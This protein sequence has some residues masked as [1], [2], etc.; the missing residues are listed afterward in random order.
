MAIRFQSAIDNSIAAVQNSMDIK[1][2]NAQEE[3][4]RLLDKIM[5]HKDDMIDVIDTWR[6]IKEK[7]LN[8]YFNKNLVY[9]S[10]NVRMIGVCIPID[11]STCKE[12]KAFIGMRFNNWKDEGGGPYDWYVLFDGEDVKIYINNIDEMATVKDMISKAVYDKQD[13]Y[14][15]MPIFDKWYRHTCHIYTKPMKALAYFADHIEDFCTE[16]F[17][18]AKNITLK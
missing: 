13:D 2:K 17:N 6:Y 8:K 3:M 5:K 4:Q 7:G 11:I 15:V 18:E 16:F 10:S 12:K 1:V 14:V 9:N